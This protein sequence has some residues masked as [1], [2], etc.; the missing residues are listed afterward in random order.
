[1]VAA[2]PLLQA[3]P[4]GACWQITLAPPGACQGFLP[5]LPQ[6]HQSEATTG[7]FGDHPEGLGDLVQGRH[8]Q[9]DAQTGAETS[10]R[11]GR[12]VA[13]VSWRPG[14]ASGGRGRSQDGDDNAQGFLA[15]TR[16]AILFRR[17]QALLCP[18]SSV[19]HLAYRVFK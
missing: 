17:A 16:K 4:A 14:D 6:V 1:M 19:G 13:P 5:R 8:M 10:W 9:G 12:E 18:A 2:N 15:R 11:N 3:Q 7:K